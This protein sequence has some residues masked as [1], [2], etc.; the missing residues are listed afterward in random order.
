MKICIIGTGYVGLVSGTCFAEMGIEVA[1]VDSNA[2]KIENLKYGRLPIYE[3][4]LE[5]LVVRNQ[6]VDRLGFTTS[7]AEAVEGAEVV[8]IAV[9]T[10]PGED[11]S[12]DL[13]HVLG[14]AQQI[15]KALTHS[16]LVVTKSTV[17]VGTTERVRDI[18]AGLTDVDFEVASNPEFLKEGNAVEDFMHPDRVVVG[19][20][21]DS[22][23]LTMERLYKPFMINSNRLIVSD[24]RSA[25][26][27]KYASNAMLATRISFINDIA[28]LC[29]LVGANVSEV[30]RGMGA[31]PR[32]GNKFLYA[33]LGYGGSCFPKDVDALI[34]TAAGLGYRMEILE[35]VERVNDRQKNVLVE[36][37]LRRFGDD[38]TGRVFGLWGLAFKPETDDV[39]QSAAVFTARELLR[40]G[41][42]VRVFDPVAM[43]AARAELGDGVVYCESMYSATQ[44]VDALLLAT[45]WKAFRV[46]DWDVVGRMMRGRLVLD[47]RNIYDARELTGLGFEYEG[48][49]V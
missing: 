24:I 46:P 23:R 40:R 48:V 6:A 39:R 25:E 16:V 7:L 18:I 37:I 41:A 22:A 14:A 2:E 12:A 28:N 1:C 33:G 10:P 45:E 4:G 9:G 43:A 47:G 42:V 34:A 32:I 44:G 36:K 13:S 31:D 15:G 5:E 29:E 27:I 35:A 3:P 30:R 19:V 8:F 49:G 20:S 38:L 17:P 11:G 26:M 21:S